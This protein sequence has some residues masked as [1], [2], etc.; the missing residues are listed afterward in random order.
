VE[1]CVTVGIAQNLL[2]SDS[3]NA[4]TATTETTI[5]DT[6]GGGGGGEG[7]DILSQRD[8]LMQD[9]Q[10]QQTQLKK[11]MTTASTDG[12]PGAGASHMNENRGGGGQG[13]VENMIPCKRQ[14]RVR[15]H[16]HHHQKHHHANNQQQQQQQQQ[17]N[18]N[19]GNDS[20]NRLLKHVGNMKRI[21]R[22]TQPAPYNT[23][24]FLMQ[25]HDH[26]FHLDLDNTED[27]DGVGGGGGGVL[28]DPS[29]GHHHHHYRLPQ[30]PNKPQSTTQTFSSS[31]EDQEYLSRDFSA[32]YDVVNA[33]RLNLMS[34]SELISEYQLL[35]ERV[36]GLERKL[37][38]A[39]RSSRPE[40]ED[41]D[42][43][44]DE[45]PPPALMTLDLM[46][47]AGG[48]EVD[49]TT[50][51]QVQEELERLKDEN[52]RIKADNRFLRRLM[53]GDIPGAVAQQQ[54]QTTRHISTS[55]TS[56]CG[57][58]TGSSSSISSNN[59]K[60]MSAPVITTARADS[61]DS[62]GCSGSSSDVGGIF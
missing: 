10:Q 28:D 30:D 18:Q 9:V 21:R 38:T 5:M 44:L 52:R 54:Y 35:E 3:T 60:M 11:T 43:E 17:N 53:Y 41:E 51:R 58:G 47:D 15:K 22:N 25:E 49:S 39:L 1:L 48:V 40:L 59:N 7:G 42:E 13:N 45:S 55:S 36:E 29:G 6:G 56:G 4:T 20:G 50:V 24:E 19:G 62:G 14:R 8:V 32:T 12:L 33:E 37:K 2:G 23:N 46:T 26:L 16:Y 57:S 61:T 31:D 34:K 27:W